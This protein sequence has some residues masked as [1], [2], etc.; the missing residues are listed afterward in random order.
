M[1][2]DS[3]RRLQSSNMVSTNMLLPLLQQ[4]PPIHAFNAIAQA[5]FGYAN[6]GQGFLE[7]RLNKSVS[8]PL[9]LLLLSSCT[10]DCVCKSP[11]VLT[12]ESVLTIFFTTCCCFSQSARQCL[13]AGICSH[14][15]DITAHDDIV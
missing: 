13:L 3:I 5:S 15:N 10:Q 4:Q 14:D 7:G 2:K 12:T 8:P 6:C 1:H 11:T 9:L